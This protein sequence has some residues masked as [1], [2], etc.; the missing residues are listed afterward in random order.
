MRP[1]GRL[2]GAT[3]HPRSGAAA[4][5]RH[6]CPR[7]GGGQGGATQ[8]PR[9]SGAGRS[10][11]TPVR[12]GDPEKPSLAGGQQ[13]GGATHAESRAGGWEEQPEER[14]LSRLRRA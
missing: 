5:R 11:L 12:G 14:W 4:K 8:H 10:H 1:R 13:L 7:S 9:P 3:L 2:G 6:L